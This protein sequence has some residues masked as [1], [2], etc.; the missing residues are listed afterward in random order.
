MAESGSIGYQ[1]VY[2][3]RKKPGASPYFPD[4]SNLLASSALV[5]RIL[6]RNVDAAKNR[7]QPSA[8]NGPLRLVS[9]T[10]GRKDPECLKAFIDARVVAAMDC[11]P[12][13]DRGTAED[14]MSGLAEGLG[15]EC[16]IIRLGDLL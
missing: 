3:F 10:G 4:N 14:I 16:A 12:D 1:A 11:I 8:L 15:A 2:T 5:D 7:D 6:K 13:T 9:W